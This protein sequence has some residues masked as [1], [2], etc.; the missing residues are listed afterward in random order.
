MSRRG[1]YKVF[2][3]RHTDG[4]E[5]HEKYPKSLIIREIQV[6][7]TMSYHLTP[8]GTVIIKITTNK[9]CWRGCGENRTL[10]L[11]VGV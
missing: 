1:K 9:K 10:T 3:I 2:Q 11:L 8:V 5:K 4:Q 7:T 6:K